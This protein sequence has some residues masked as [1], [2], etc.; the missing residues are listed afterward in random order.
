MKYDRLILF[1]IMFILF[2][3]VPISAEKGYAMDSNMN[4]GIIT[5][6]EPVKDGS[7]SVEEALWNRRTT[8]SFSTKPLS[9][10]DISQLLWAGQGVTGSRGFR[11]APS[12]GAL[13][14][15]EI[16]V[17]A[18][19]VRNLPAGL[20]HYRSE[21]HDL[22][23]VSRGDY[24]T[25][26][27]E[28]ALQQSAIMEAGAVFVITGIFSR[29]TEKYGR[30]GMQYVLIETGHVAQNLILQAEAMGIGHAPIGAFQDEVLKEVLKIDQN[31][32]PLYIIPV[33]YK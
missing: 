33:G 25:S 13:Y 8:R 28:A 21:S 32:H 10:Q 3:S 5:L 27:W 2:A 23:I 24:R 7:V 22:E 6:P 15:L 31:A 26:I 18:G 14:P 12:A 11:T 19:N 30:R 17:A 4:S 16:Y 29:S 9:L 1:A 20:Y